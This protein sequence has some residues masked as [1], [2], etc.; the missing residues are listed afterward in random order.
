MQKL[1]K[2]TPKYLDLIR[3]LG[4]ARCDYLLLNISAVCN[5]N[6]KKCCNKMESC[7]IRKVTLTLP[8]IKQI[9]KKAQDQLGIRTVVL[10]GE[11]E[12]LLAPHFKEIISYI[13][14]L[15][16][17]TII[18][19]TAFLLNREMAEFLRNNN[20]SII[21][22]CDSLNQKKYD[23]L[24]GVQG[25]FQSAIN[26]I[27]SCAEIYS[28]TKGFIELKSKQYELHRL[29][30]NSVVTDETIDEIDK[31]QEF[32]R[33]RGMMSILNYPIIKGNLIKHRKELI[34]TQT[35]LK[36]QMKIVFDKSENQGFS[37]TTYDKK[38]G[39]L[40]NGLS[41]GIDGS[42]LLPCAYCPENEKLFGNVLTYLNKSDG[43]VGVHNKVR[44]VITDFDRG[45]KIGVC[46]PRNLLYY[47][48]FCKQIL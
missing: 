26:N 6:C 33:S 19:T 37:G 11:G 47:N 44:K 30:F 3:P 32:C 29:A 13:N 36:K 46:L 5:Y 22:S 9:I 24:V 18:F 8:Q 20:V 25:A 31:I 40:F 42:I 23:D 48:K 27:E 15:G 28:E 41:I 35:S 39:Y 45:Y 34:K 2:G 38:C 1:L 12:T 21:I 14:R 16:L 7:E 43:F 17:I 10:V 4:K